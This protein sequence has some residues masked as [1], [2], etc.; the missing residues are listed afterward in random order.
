MTSGEGS[1]TDLLGAAAQLTPPFVLICV[2]EAGNRVEPANAQ[3][4]DQNPG[5][6]CQRRPY[7]AL[8]RVQR[9]ASCCRKGK[10]SQIVSDDVVRRLTALLGSAMNQFA[11]EP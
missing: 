8:T 6:W 2:E 5:S 11:Y 10:R 3:R 9:A 7:L 1:G 4:V